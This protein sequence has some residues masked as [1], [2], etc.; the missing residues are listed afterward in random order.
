MKNHRGRNGAEEKY[1]RDVSELLK[2][3]EV[4][5]ERWRCR[6]A[7]AAVTE[8]PLRPKRGKRR[9]IYLLHDDNAL[10]GSYERALR[11]MRRHID[12]F[13]AEHD[14]SSAV[15]RKLW[16]PTIVRRATAM[17]IKMYQATST[18]EVT[19]DQARDFLLRIGKAL[20]R[21]RRRYY[22]RSVTGQRYCLLVRTAGA[23]REMS[24]TEWAVI[25]AAED[26]DPN[27]KPR[28]PLKICPRLSSEAWA[29]QQELSLLGGY[30]KSKLYT[31]A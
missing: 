6:F 2:M 11:S 25:G 19:A 31:D 29:E 26:I 15:R 4:F 23:S 27:R 8:N 24:F 7:S 5:R 28:E 30:G 22:V 1:E 9:V 18:R 16:M 21:G 17:R 3:V 20:P 13:V 14:P 10:F 12:A